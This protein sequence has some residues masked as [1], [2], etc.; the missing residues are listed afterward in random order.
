MACYQGD[1]VEVKRLLASGVDPSALPPVRR[2]GAKTVRLRYSRKTHGQFPRPARYAAAELLR[3]GYQVGSGALVPVW[4]DHVLPLLVTR[5]TAPCYEWSIRGYTCE[6]GGDE[7]ES[8]S[9]ASTN[10]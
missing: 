1:I 10:E 6:L 2:R 5:T 9:E 3:L 7:S 4:A 8:E